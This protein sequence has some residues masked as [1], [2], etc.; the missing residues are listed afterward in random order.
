MGIS[1]SCEWMTLSFTITLFFDFDA[2]SFCFQKKFKA[3]YRRKRTPN[4]FIIDI[5]NSFISKAVLNKAN[6]K[7]F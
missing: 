4:T 7:Q 5:S 6:L 1:K 2:F 3:K